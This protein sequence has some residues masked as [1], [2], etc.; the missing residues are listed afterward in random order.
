M[1]KW[2]FA[3]EAERVGNK[4]PYILGLHSRR[5][6]STFAPEIVKTNMNRMKKY[7][8]AC[9][10]GLMMTATGG[11]ERVEARDVALLGLFT[12]GKQLVGESTHCRHHNDNGTRLGIDNIP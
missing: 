11:L 4:N 9:T 7:V 10:A 5:K 6:C 2:N 3:W 8:L 12:H 1:S